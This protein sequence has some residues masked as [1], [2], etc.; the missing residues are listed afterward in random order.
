MVPHILSSSRLPLK[1]SLLNSGNVGTFVDKDHPNTY[2]S[3]DAGQTWIQ[4]AKNANNFEIA[5]H[6]AIT[7][8]VADSQLTAELKFVIVLQFMTDLITDSTQISVDTH[9]R[10]V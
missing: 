5:N 3:R 2:L 9:G 1:R 8:L 6:G 10:R 7:L 4:I